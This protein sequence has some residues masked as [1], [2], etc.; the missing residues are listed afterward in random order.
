MGD[1]AATTSAVKAA[2]LVQAGDT[3]PGAL[4]HPTLSPCRRMLEGTE[5]VAGAGIGSRRVTGNG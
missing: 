1:V 2:D 5:V 4:S 3:I